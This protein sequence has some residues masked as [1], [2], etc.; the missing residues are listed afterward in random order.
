MRSSLCLL[1]FFGRSRGGRRG[2]KSVAVVVVSSS[3]R[4]GAN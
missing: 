3:A 4:F 1:I 2:A